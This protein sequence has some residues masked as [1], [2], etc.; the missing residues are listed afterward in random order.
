MSCFAKELLD[1]G[2]PFSSDR[3]DVV[4]D[5]LVSAGISGISVRSPGVFACFGVHP[6]ADTRSC[7]I[8]RMSCPC[9]ARC[10]ACPRL[11]YGGWLT[12]RSK[13]PGPPDLGAEASVSTCVLSHS[14]SLLCGACVCRQPAQEKGRCVECGA[15]VRRRTPGGAW[16][17]AVGGFY[18]WPEQSGQDAGISS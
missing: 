3:L 17:G 4:V 2:F 5:A 18:L 7:R 13:L 1:H 6:R 10:G 11:S 8:R 12:S 9:A 16:C 15:V 14:K